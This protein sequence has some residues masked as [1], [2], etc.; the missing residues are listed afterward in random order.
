MGIKWDSILL[1]NQRS[2]KYKIRNSELK[3]TSMEISNLEKSFDLV[4]YKHIMRAE[5]H[6]QIYKQTLLWTIMLIQKS[7]IQSGSSEDSE[8]Y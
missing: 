1:V 7:K 4:E 5:N 8:L 2:K 6:K 3:T